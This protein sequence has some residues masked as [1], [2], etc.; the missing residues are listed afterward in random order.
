MTNL[1]QDL[2]HAAR[3]LLKNPGFSVVAVATLALGIGANTAIFS[4]VNGV[5][6]R[7]LP[8][9]EP[10]RLAFLGWDWGGGPQGALTSF[11]FDYWRE[12]GQVFDGVSVS[13]SVV[14]ELEAGDRMDDV[15]GL[16]VTEDFLTVVAA[17]PALGRR[18]LPEEMRPGG[19]QVVILGDALW[20]SRFGADSGILGEVVRIDGEPHTV[21]GVLGADFSYPPSPTYTDLLLPLRLVPNRADGGHNYLPLARLSAGVTPDQAR[22]AMRG[23]FDRFQREHPDLAQGENE[24]G[25]GFRSYQDVYVGG[26]QRTLWILLSAVGLVLL[27]AC[28]NVASLLLGRA[29]SRRREMATR[30]ALGAGRGRIIRQLLSESLV[31]AFVAGAA[32]LLLGIWSVE[33]LLALL[34]QGLPRMNEI[35]LDLRVL[36]FT[37]LL[38]LGTGIGFGLAAAVPASRP[39]LATALKQD[40]S[41]GRAGG[42]RLRWALVAGEAALAMILL[43]GAGLLVVSFLQLRGVETGFN[44]E[45]VV[46]ADLG[47]MP[48]GYRSG[49]RLAALEAQIVERVRSVPGVQAAATATN[50][51]LQRGWNIPITVEGRPEATEGDIEWRAVGPGYFSAL[52][53]PVLAGR[54]FTGS[55]HENGVPVAII[56]EAT[57]RHYWPDGDAIGQRVVIGAYQ[58]RHVIPDFEDP[59]RE[60]IGVVA[61]VREMGLELAPKRTVYVPQA[62]ALPGMI[63]GLPWLMVRTTQ[64]DLVPGAVREALAEADPRL[65]EPVFGSMDDVVAASVAQERFNAVLLVSF[66]VTALLLTMIGIFGVVSYSVRQRTHEIGV[67]MAL[68]AGASQVRKLIVAQGMRAVMVGV[69]IGLVGAFLLTRLLSGMLFGVEPWDPLTFA[70]VVA[71]LMSVALLATYLPARR[72]TRMDPMIALRAE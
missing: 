41:G 1:L 34:P 35:G 56:N 7:P 17:T 31:L 4:V 18:F 5:V 55:D 24:R 28:A 30:A 57:A 47:R 3:Q 37:F 14:A 67:R 52:E 26:L 72:A 39:E 51:P 25:V 9:P 42:V 2:R 11:K 58:G 27:I 36:G 13:S 21:I 60:I 54:P 19:P 48:D 65:R 69:G 44:P 32:G 59:V 6:L 33:I 64:P 20:R 71:L 53:I 62:Q 61:D 16:R 22:A 50:L 70:A 46:T 23:V 38:A 49:A 63:W 66:A 10:D 45:N 43:A 8:F 29:A 40:R 12:H 15:R 68:G